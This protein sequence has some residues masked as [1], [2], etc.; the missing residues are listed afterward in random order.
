VGGECFILIIS[1]TTVIVM[2]KA[3]HKGAA[4]LG[5]LKQGAPLEILFKE[6][7][8]EVRVSLNTICSSIIIVIGG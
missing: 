7:W 8:W 2:V 6:G 5:A 1:I 3:Q 4:F